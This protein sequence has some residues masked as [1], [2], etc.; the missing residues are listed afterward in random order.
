MTKNI[1]V[2]CLSVRIENDPDISDNYKLFEFVIAHERMF[3]SKLRS[4]G[5]PQ[6]V[7]FSLLRTWREDSS[8]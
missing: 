4:Y 8:R 7:A 2:D 6:H 3:M 1:E 5:H